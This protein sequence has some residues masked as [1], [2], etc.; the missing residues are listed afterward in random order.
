MKT[1]ITSVIASILLGSAVTFYSCKD[2]ETEPALSAKIQKIAP[3]ALL[4]D[5]KTKGMPINEGVKPPKVD[6]IFV[7]SP[8]T[9]LVPY[10]PDDPNQ[11]GY[12]FTDLTIQF[13]NQN[14]EDGSIVIATKSGS[15]TSKG[16]GGFISGSGNKFSIF[17]ELE[18]TNGSATGKQIRIFSGE[19][20]PDGI[21]DLVT[22]L[23]FTEKND[24]GDYFLKVGQAR[25]I[26]D[27]DGLARK[28]N[29]FRV[30]ERGG[31]E[32]LRDENVAQ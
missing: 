22:T 19:I 26:K 3:E 10:G 21:K 29:S 2:K 13:S 28:I 11:A 15:T 14:F 12:Q 9:C 17:A 27:N 6:G 18:I 5:L 25:I 23:V 16:F 30:S 4:T 24:P 7:S 1:L 31:E 32:F 20:T 8:H